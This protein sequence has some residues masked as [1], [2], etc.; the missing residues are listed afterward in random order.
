MALVRDHVCANR[1]L[2]YGEM[3]ICE[4]STVKEKKSGVLSAAEVALENGQMGKD[5]CIVGKAL[6]D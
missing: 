6:E 4:Q 1:E 5:R 3:E 2:I